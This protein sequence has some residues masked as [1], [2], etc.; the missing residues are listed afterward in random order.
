MPAA[1]LH[2]AAA[3][4]ASCPAPASLSA[5]PSRSPCCAWQ[6][7][8]PAPRRLAAAPRCRPPVLP[9]RQ[10]WPPRQEPA[11]AWGLQVEGAVKSRLAHAQP[12]LSTCPC[13]QTNAFLPSCPLLCVDNALI[14]P[15][16]SSWL[17]WSQHKRCDV[18]CNH[19]QAHLPTPP[20]PAPR[21]PPPG[22]RGQTPRPPPAPQPRP[23]LQAQTR[24]RLPS[25]ASDGWQDA[26][27]PQGQGWC[28]K[29]WRRHAHITACR[30]HCSPTALPPTHATPQTAHLV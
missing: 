10:A 13:C 21:P 8:G 6:P 24:S 4:I 14:P 2:L 28:Q 20:P 9:F 1:C 5:A 19:H 22:R 17:C 25:E 12:V 7:E 11:C 26:G 30:Q 23:A 3:L 18:R 27:A 29:R 15:C 16:R